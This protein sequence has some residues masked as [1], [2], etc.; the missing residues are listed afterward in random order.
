MPWYRS[1]SGFSLIELLIGIAIVGV[2]M[3]L[4]IPLLND[5]MRNSKVRARAE[6]ILW[7]L[8]Q[9]RVDALKR[10]TTVWHQFVDSLDATCALSTTGPYWVVSVGSAVGA[11]QTIPDPAGSGVLAK[12]DPVALNADGGSADGVV[13]TSGS[14]LFCFS[15]L[16]QLTAT[17]CTSGAVTGAAANTDID[18]TLPSAGA[19][20][21]STAN[22]GVACM[23]VAVR[24]GGQIRLCDPVIDPNGTDSR[25][26]IP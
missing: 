15:S 24:S 26:C 7:S 14:A 16:G 12:S 19:C 23:R 20:R 25:R 22:S 9:S 5:V 13:V 21:T 10:N 8:Q 18:V 6:N 1:S 11:C 17:S 4:G 2:L 3:S